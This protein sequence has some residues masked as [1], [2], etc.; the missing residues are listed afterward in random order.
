MRWMGHSDMIPSNPGILNVDLFR[1]D[2]GTLEEVCHVA[3]ESIEATH[4]I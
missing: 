2:K 4:G 1:A 3:R